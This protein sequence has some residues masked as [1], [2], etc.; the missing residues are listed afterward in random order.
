M[1]WA[2]WLTG[3]AVALIWTT[4]LRLSVRLV[5]KKADNGWDN[6]IG[7]GVVTALMWFPLEWIFGLRSLPLLVFFPFALWTIQTLTL[8]WIYEIRTLHAWLL[9]LV[10][11]L[12]S[13]VVIS[14][15][16]MAAG[17]VAAYVLYGKIVSDPMFLIRTILRLIGIDLPLDFPF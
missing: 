14:T 12:I 10:H 9:G 5:A 1:T 16:T 13:T 15:L 3:A 11:S 7:Y 8:R 17:A 6:A 2:L 4:L